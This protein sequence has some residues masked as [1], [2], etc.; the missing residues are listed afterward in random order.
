MPPSN[1]NLQM[2]LEIHGSLFVTLS[3]QTFTIPVKIFLI[4]G[5][6][7]VIVSYCEWQVLCPMFAG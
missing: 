1:R 5:F 3:L 7:F 6:S 2:I 4:T